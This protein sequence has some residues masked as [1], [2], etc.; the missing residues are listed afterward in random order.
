MAHNKELLNMFPPTNLEELKSAIINICTLIPLSICKRI[1]KHL[2]ERWKLC[3]KQGRRRLDKE[4]IR[5]IST[6]HKDIKW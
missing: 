4:L 6:F 1:I 3:V 5:K 2:C